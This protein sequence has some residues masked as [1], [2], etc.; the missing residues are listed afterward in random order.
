[1]YLLS[2]MT[3]LKL[4]VCFLVASSFSEHP[5]Q[6]LLLS[7][8]FVSWYFGKS[9]TLWLNYFRVTSN[10][11]ATA[12]SS[13]SN[14]FAAQNLVKGLPNARD[15]SF[16]LKHP[17]IPKVYLLLWHNFLQFHAVSV[18]GWC[19]VIGLQLQWMFLHNTYVSIT[20]SRDIPIE[21]F[22]ILL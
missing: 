21:K 7:A 15:F 5:A 3:L 10:P 9:T 12:W 20:I 16:Q 22:S 11:K 14:L 17:Q 6:T 13:S 19:C 8:H 18:P 4:Y 2:T 1:M